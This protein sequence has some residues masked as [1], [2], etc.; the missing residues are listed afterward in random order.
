MQRHALNLAEQHAQK[1]LAKEVCELVH[2]KTE[3]EKAEFQSQILFAGGLN[4][5]SPGEIVEIFKGDKRFI[6]LDINLMDDIAALGAAS[7]I[8]PSK[9]AVNKMIK[10][11]GFYVNDKKWIASNSKAVGRELLVNEKILLL[12]SGKFNYRIVYLEG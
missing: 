8:L 7:G 12:R 3:S 11:G 1:N 10:S 4:K 9:S 6:K 5:F 2:G